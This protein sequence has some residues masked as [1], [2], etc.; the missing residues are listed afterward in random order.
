MPHKIVISEILSSKSWFIEKH[1]SALIHPLKDSVKQL[2]LSSD[3]ACRHIGLLNSLL[4]QDKCNSLLNRKDYFNAVKQLKM[5]LIQPLYVRELRYFRH[6]HFLRLLVLELAGIATTEEVMRSWSDCADAII[7]HTLDFCK[8]SI[9]SRYGIPRDDKGKEVQIFTLAM[10]KLGG[11]ELNYSSDIDLIFAFSMAGTTDGEEPIS[12]QQYFNKI[13][14]LFMQVLQN[15]TPDGFVFRV[16]LRLRPNG[17]SGPLVSNLAAME[18]YYQEQGRDWERYAMVK[19]R[20]ISEDIDEVHPWFDRLIIPFVYRRY[21]DFSVIESLRSMKAMIE[22]EVQLN[23]RLDDIKRGQGGIR[24]VEFIIQN[25]QLIRG[26][27]LPQLQQQNAMLALAALKKEQLLP[28][29][30][31][32]KQAYLYLRKL[33]NVLQSLNDQQTHSLPDDPIKQAQIIMAMGYSKWEDLL[34]RLQQYQRI[35]SHSF[36]S[37]LGKVEAYED[38]KRLLANQLAS[39]WQGHVEDT[40]A[41]N[42][43]TSLGF[44]NS[45]HCYQMLHAFRH[46]PRCRRL[47][48][49]ARIRLDRFMVLLLTELTYFAN[50][51]EVLL[52]VMHLLENIVGRSAYLALLTEN[53]QALK[54]LLFWFATSPFITN[55]L[56]NQPF[57]LEVLLDQEQDWK[58]HSRHQ[59]EQILHEKLS[60]SVDMELQEETLRQFKL[61]NWLMAAR[62]ELYGLRN[63]VRI[64]QFLSD[65]AQVIVA[66]VLVIASKQL[67]LRYPEMEQIKSRFAIIAYGTLGSREMNYTSDLDLVFLHTAQTSEEALVTRLT[68]KILHMLTTRSQAGVLYSVDTRLRPSGAAGLLVSHVDAFIEYQKTQAW[69]WEHQALLKARIIFGNSKIK[70]S[71]LQL[72]KSVFSISRDSVTLQQEVITMRAKIEQH[73]EFDPLKHARGGLLDLEFLVQFLV[74]NLHEPKLA[75]FTHTLSQIK[76]LFFAD[77]LSEKN[78]KILKKAYQNYHFLLHQKIVQTKSV[79]SNEMQA[80]VLAICESIYLEQ[81]DLLN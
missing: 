2:V 66:Q 72:K 51:D 33:E 81:N 56:V 6:T 49:G 23:P 78:Y 13:V 53:S 75:R 47:P 29:S 38:E 32:L 73:Q 62:A 15:I 70:H 74:L 5:D 37:V 40:M 22:R 68:Q 36:H 80:R 77:I 35:I 55:L 4:D 18:T 3:Y 20:V 54:E 28:R 65:V 14:Q 69:T 25:F 46:G 19:A 42:M 67:S 21:V 10:G 76:Q 61:T 26:G 50:T 79:N 48:Q 30:D 9:S 17:D 12:N 71:L 60:H 39:L 44:E 58:P 31:A 11:R 52:Q 8:R 57:L 24:E 45:Q 1:L 41:I 7:L 63:A 64:G 43:L 34:A 27:R 59:L 16:D